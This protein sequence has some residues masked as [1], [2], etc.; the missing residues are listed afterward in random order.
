MI[1]Y[2]RIFFGV[3]VACLALQL[4]L[5]SCSEERKREAAR[6]AAELEAKERGETLPPEPIVL[7]SAV[8]AAGDTTGANSGPV[9]QTG[10]LNDE[11]AQASVDSANP[12]VESVR[13]EPSNRLAVPGNTPT[14]MPPVI[15]DGWTVQV[16]SSPL[17]SYVESQMQ[18]FKDRG[19]DAYVGTVT[20]EDK[21][22]YR[23]RI[24]RFTDRAEAVRV[25]TEINS[26]YNLQS[27]VDRAS[28]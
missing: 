6:L 24:G 3:A 14:S 4:S 26:M 21:T 15:T 17:Q 1:Q 20:K 27:W 5:V 28:W 23:L 9:Q 10:Q 16:E 2:K 19:Y 7:D 13:V 18:V 25:S 8:L 12:V 11:V 22:F